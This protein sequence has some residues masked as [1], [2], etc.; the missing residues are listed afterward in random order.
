MLVN[1]KLPS[2]GAGATFPDGSTEVAVR[3]D[4]VGHAT[5][6]TMRATSTVGSFQVLVSAYLARTG[7]SVPM[8]SQYA[9]TPFEPPVDNNGT[10]TRNPN[11]NTPV[12]AAALLAD[13]TR[14]LGRGRRRRWSGTSRVQLRF[15]VN[16]A[17]PVVDQDRG[18]HL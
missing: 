7:V 15:R 17:D 12:A 14:L 11:A 1:F 18:C 9:F 8:A 3:T 13:G 5:A 16:G 4:A 10:L 2:S 6:P